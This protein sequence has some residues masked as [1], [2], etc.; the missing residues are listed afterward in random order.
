MYWLYT[1]GRVD[2]DYYSF[3]VI[4]TL[5]FLGAVANYELPA[6]SQMAHGRHVN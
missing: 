3:A 1:R 2:A 5:P 4:C 6:A